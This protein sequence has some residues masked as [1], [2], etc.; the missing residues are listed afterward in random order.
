MEDNFPSRS[1]IS[2]HLVG[3]R[4][5]TSG[6][7]A[8]TFTHKA[9]VS[10]ACLLRFYARLGMETRL[11]VK[12]AFYQPHLHLRVLFDLILASLRSQDRRSRQDSFTCWAWVGKQKVKADSEK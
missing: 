3:L 8:R 4:A 12:Q 9:T 7:V 5:Q 6:L 1:G 11:H 2:V 10:P